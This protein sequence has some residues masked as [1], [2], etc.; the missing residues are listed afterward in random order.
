[1]MVPGF[2]LFSI[3]AIVI[4]FPATFFGRDKR[5]TRITHRDDFWIRYYGEVGLIRLDPPW[6]TVNLLGQIQSRVRFLCEQEILVDWVGM[7]SD[8]LLLDSFWVHDMRLNFDFPVGNIIWCFAPDFYLVNGNSYLS[9]D[10]KIKYRGD[11]Y[12]VKERQKS[13]ICYG[14][15]DRNHREKPSQLTLHISGKYR[16]IVDWDDFLPNGGLSIPFWQRLSNRLTQIVTPETFQIN[17]SFIFFMN[18]VF[19]NLF[20]KTGWFSGEPFVKRRNRNKQG[21]FLLLDLIDEEVPDE[22]GA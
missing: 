19:L 8:D 12:T 16:E 20:S 10:H 18:P 5:F 17:P 1:M 4:G 11:R 2:P 15:L 21:D 9:A 7:L 3:G 6:G 13:L 22:I 14:P